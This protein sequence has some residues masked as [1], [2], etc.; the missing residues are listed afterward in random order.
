MKNKNM[1]SII[2]R[3][4]TFFLLG[5]LLAG[6]MASAQVVIEGNVYGGGNIGEVVKTADDGT[7]NTTVTVNGGTVGKK[8]GLEERKYDKDVQITRVDYGNVYGG[9][10]G[11]E[12]IGTNPNGSPIFNPNAGRVQGNT[13]VYV[14]GEAV[15]RRAVYGGGNIATVGIATIPQQTGIAA[16][17]SGGQATV[18]ITGN[19]LIGP[20]MED[21]TTATAEELA[22]SGIANQAD[23]ADSAFKYLGG[24]EGWVFGSS[25]GISG[26]ALRHLSFVDETFVNINGNAQVMNVFGSGENGH[27]QKGTNVIVGGN[28]IVGGVPLHGTSTPAVYTV[29][30]GAYNGATLHLKA[31]E[32]ELIEDE[33]GVGRE[34]TRGNVFGGGKGSDFISWF[35]NPKYCYT[36]GR[37]YGNT[38]VTIEENAKIYNRVFGGGLIAMVGTFV[39]ETSDDDDNHTIIGIASGGHTYVNIN[40]GTIG[41]FSATAGLTGLNNGD[42]YGGGRGLPGR[43]RKPGTG[44]H[45]LEPLAPLHQVVDEAYVGHTHVTVTDG[46]IYN[47]VYGGGANGHVQGNTYVTI[48]GGTIGHDLG[49][50][51]GNVFAGGGGTARYKEN[52]ALNLSITAGR[53]FGDTYLEITG[54]HVLHNVYGGGAIASVGTYNA[55]EL[56]NPTHPYLGFGHSNITITGGEIGTDGDNNGMV[57]GSG[58]GEIAEPGNFLDYVT[59]VAFSEVNIGTGTVNASTGEA[60]NL[61]GNAK[62]NGSVYGS[63]ENGHTYMEAVINVFGGTIGCTADEYAAMTAD[64]KEKKFPFRGN[65]YGAGCGTDR[66]ILNIVGT[67]TTWAYNPLAGVVQGNTKVNI[68]GGKISRSVYG[69]GAMASVGSFTIDEAHTNTN[70]SAALSWPYKLTYTTIT[71]ANNEPVTTG[72]TEVNIRGGHIGTLAAPVAES[73]NVFGSARGDVGPLGTMETM[74]IVRE[75]EVEVNFAPPT[76]NVTD[77]TPNVIIGSVYG[78]GENGT[79]YENTKVTMTNG[80]V[81]GSVFGGGDGT[82]TYMVALK[83]P[84]NPSSYLD[85]SPQRSITSGKVYGNTEVVINGGQVLHNVFGGGNLASVGKGNYMGYGELTNVSASPEPY[86]SS[87][88]CTVTVNGG[89][90][91]TTGYPG[92][93]YNNG[94]VFGSSKGTTFATVDNPEGTARY[95]YNRDFFLGYVNKTIVNI[96][97]TEG[98]GTG[99]QI[100]GAVFGGG[101]NGHVRWHTYV[102]VNKGEIGEE[103]DPT[104]GN[105]TDDKW[106][107][108]GNVYG[109]GLGTDMYDSDGDGDLDSYCPSAGSVTLNTNVT[110]NG[111][112]IHRN[113]YGGGSMATVG[114][115][116]TTDY[117]PGTSTCTVNINGGTIGQVV[118]PTSGAP[119][120]YGGNV[121]GAG[122]G[123]IDEHAPLTQYAAAVNTEVNVQIGNE[124]D[125]VIGNVYGGGSYG[126]VQEETNVNMK[127]GHVKG[128]VFGGGMGFETEVIAGLVKGNAT[129]DMTGGTIERSIYGGGQMGSVGTFTT[130][131]D[132][133]YNEGQANAFTSG[134]NVGLLGSLMP[135]EDHNPDDDDRGWIFCGGQGV[136]DSI[137]YPKAIALGVV[138]CTHLQISN[139]TSGENTIRPVVTASVYGG[140]ENGLVL[141]STFVEIAGGQIGT[142]HYKTGTTHHF[143]PI[144]EEDKWTT[145]ITA[146]NNGTIETALGTSGSL[147]DVFHECDAWEYSNNQLYDIFADETGYNS[148]GGALVGTNG[149]SFFGNVFG[150][151]SGYYPI[152]A[153]VWRRTA[154]QVNGNTRVEITGGHILTAVYGGNET[155][156][157]KGKSTV[158]MNG[159]TVGIPRTAVQIAAN[160]LSGNIYGAGMGDPRSMFNT[161]TNVKKT[162][163][164]LTGGTVFGNVYGGSR[165]G[166]VLDSTLVVIGQEQGKSTLIGTTGFSG[167]D[168]LVFGGGMGNVDYFDAEGRKFPVGR[169][170]GNTHVRM[171]DGKVL[172]SIYGGGLVALGG[173]NVEGWIDSHYDA[174]NHGRAKVEVSGGVIGNYAHDGLDLLL[175]DQHVGNVFGG[176][177]GSVEE[178]REDDLGRVGNAVVKISG[179][180]T[181]YGSVYGGGQMANVGFWDDYDQWYHEGTAF[182]K[183]SISGS[184][185]IGTQKE[186][187]PD[188]SSGTGTLTPKWTFYDVI[189]GVKMINHTLTGNVFGGGKGDVKLDEDGYV[190]GLEHGHCGSSE[191]SIS[192]TPTIRSSVFGGSERGAVW[193]DAKVNI[194]GGTIGTV[195]TGTDQQQSTYNFGSVF[196][197]SYGADA[198]QHFDM[199]P[200]NQTLEYL[201]KVDSVNLLAGRVYG[202]TSVDITG[203]VVRGNVFGGGDMASVGIWDKVLDGNDNLIDIVAKNDP[204]RPAFRGNATVNVG[205]E[206]VIGPLDNT[207]LNAYVFGGGKGFSY[208]P[209]EL[210]KA[211]SN[212]DSTFVTINGGKIWGSVYGG[213]SD[214]HVLGST[215]VIV[216]SGANIGDD[217]LS[218]WDGNIFGGGRNFFNSNHTNGRVAGNVTIDMDGGT[219]QGSV[220]GGGR[221]A[222]TGVN[223]LGNP[224][225]TEHAYDSAFNNKPIHGLATINVSGTATTANGVTTYSTNIGNPNGNELLNGSNESVG[226][227]YG[228]G[229]GDTKNYEDILAG[230]V[231]NTKVGISGSPRIYGSVFGGGEMAGVGYWYTEDGKAKFYDKSGTSEVTIGREGESD[232]PVIGTDYEFTQEYAATNPEWTIYDD[233]GT[234]IHTCTGNVFGGCQGDVD[235][236]APH[237]VSMG[238]SRN[239]K[240]VVNGGT[241]KSRVFGGAEQGSMAGNTSV[242]IN[243]G[244]IG[245]LV[246]MSTNGGGGNGDGRD[247]ETQYYM[248]G[249]Y[250]GG[251]GSHNSAYNVPHNNDSTNI[252]SDLL[253]G[254]VYG[255]ARVDVLGGTV[256]GSVFGGAS[257]AYLGG[258]GTNP[259]GNAKVYIGS[260]SQMGIPDVGTTIL[261]GVYGAN[262]YNGTPYGDVEVHVYHTAHTGQPTTAGGNA[263]PTVPASGATP[264]WLAT[265]PNGTD[266]FALYQVFGGGNRANYTPKLAANKATV[267]VYG[268]EENTIYELYGGGNAAE[269]G[270][271]TA[272][273][274]TDANVIIEGGRIHSVFG[275][276]NG[277]PDPANIYGIA[278]TSVEGGLIDELFGGSNGYGNV[279]EINLVVAE[280]SDCELAIVNGYGGGN[281]SPEI[282]EIIATLECCSNPTPYNNF[283]GGAHSAVIYGN[284]TLNVYGGKVTNLFGG[285]EGSQGI[286]ADIKKYPTDWQTG[287]Y[288]DE[289]K[290][291]MQSHPDLAGTG[292][293]VTVNLYGGTHTNVFGGCDVNG[294]IEGVVTVN[295]LDV[296]D[297]CPLKIANIYGASNETPYTPD[298]IIVENVPQKPVSP[299]INVVHIKDTDGISQNVFGAGK[300]NTATVTS[301]PMVNIGYNHA[302]M[303]QYIPLDANGDSI[304]HVQGRTPRAYVKGSVYGGGEYG[305]VIGNPS[306]NINRSNTVVDNFVYG[307]GCG[308]DTDIDCAKVTGGTTVR[309]IDGLIKRSV[310]GGGEMA[311]VT[312]DTKVEMSGGTVGSWET[313]GD[314]QYLHGSI[315]GGGQGSPNP[316]NEQ[317]MDAADYGR[318]D[319]NT[320]IDI[321]GN[322]HILK[323]VY[324]GGQMGSVGNGNLSDNTTG[325]A[326][327]T[328]SGGQIGPFVADKKNANVYG[329]GQGEVD[330][331]YISHYTTHAN[332]DS[333]SVIVCDS[334]LI[335]GSVFG[336]SANGHVLAGTRVLVEKGTNTKDKKP[337]IGT[338]GMHG[339]DGHVYGGGQGNTS[340]FSAGRVGGNTKVVMT[341]GTVMGCIYGGGNVAL[342]GVDVDGTFA[343]FID[344]DQKYDSI[345]HGM[346]EVVVSGGIIGNPANDGLDLLR[347]NQK[348]G[349]IY[350]GGRGDPNEYLEDDFGRAANA[351]VSISGSPTIYGSVFGGGQMA[352]VGHWNNYSDW[353]TTQ[354]GTTRVTINGAPQIGTAL[355]FDHDN[356]AIAEPLPIKTLYDTINDVRMISHTSTGNVFGGGQGDMIIDEEGDAE[357]FEQG[358][359]CTTIVNINMNDG[360]HIMSSVF[361][362]SEQGAVWGDTKVKIERGVI[363]TSGIEADSLDVDLDEW[364][365]ASNLYRFGSVFGGSYGVDSYKHL[366]S[367]DAA[368]ADTANSYAGRVYGNTYVNITGGSICGNVFGGGNMASVGYWNKVLDDNDNLIDFVPAPYPNTIGI[369][370][371]AKVN[372]S[373]AAIIGPLDPNGLNASVYGGGKGIGDD[374]DDLR[375]KYGNV[376]STE[377]TINLGETGHVY[378]S[379]FGGGADG[380]VLRDAVVNITGGTIGTTGLHDDGLVFGGGQGTSGSFSAGRVGGN[381]KVEMTDGTVLGNI[382]GGG[383][384]ALTGVDVNGSFESYESLVDGVHVYDSIRHGLARVEVSGGTIGNHNHSGLDLLLNDLRVGNIYGGGRGDLNEFREDDFGRSANAMVHIYNSPTIYGSVYGGGQMANVGRWNDYD[385][386]Y[387]QKTGATKVTIDGTPTI[388]TEKEF[389]YAYSTGTGASAPKWTLYEVIN[390]MRMITYTRTGNVYGS[391]Q[392]NIKLDNDGYVVG[393]E[394]GHCRT[395]EVN[396]S[397]TPTI[398]SSVYGGAEQ[399]AVWGDT[400]VNITGG[401]IGTENIVAGNSDYYSYGSVYGGSYG[402]DAYTHL[403][404]TNPSQQVL[405]SV[406]DLAGHVYGNTFV[407]ITGGAVRC[408]VFGGGDMASVGEWDDD[409]VPVSNTGNATV[410]VS[411]S[412]IVGPMDGTGLNAYVFG[413]GKGIG[414][415]P[416]N[417]RKEYCNINSTNVTVELNE[418]GDNVGRVYGSLY[419]GGSDCHVLGDTYV[420]LNSGVIGTYDAEHSTISSW[421]GNIFGGGRNFLKTNYAAGR[422]AG[423]THVEMKGGT[424]YGAIFGGG[425]HA[426]TG[427]GLDGMTMLDGENH[428]NTN[429]EV[430]GGIVGC[431]DIVTSFIDRPIGEVYGGGKGSMVGITLPGH[432]S[433][434]ALFIS[435]VKNTNVEISQANPAVPTRILNTV[436][437]GG[438]TANVGHYTWTTD[439]NG[440]EIS[441]IA[442]KPGTGKTNVTIKG[443]I[444]GVDRSVMSYTLVPGTYTLASNPVGNV[445]GGGKGL[446][447][448][449]ANYA[450]GISTVYGHKN[451]VDIMGTVGSTTVTVEN[452]SETIRPW[453]KGSVFGGSASGHV[454]RDTEVTIAGGQ[455]GAGDSG[456]ADV[457]YT[458]GEDNNQFFNPIEYF[459][460]EHTDLDDVASE[461]ALYEC[462]HWPYNEP[463]RP[464]DILEIAAGNTP[465]DGKT[466]FGNVYGGGSGFLPYIT[467]NYN[468]TADTA[469]W[470]RESGKVYGNTK[471]TITGGHILTNVYGGCETADVGL[472]DDNL[473]NISGGNDTIIMTGGT[474]GV[475]RTLAQIAAHPLTCYLFGA[476]KGDPRTQFD[477]WTNVDS[478]YVEVSG[479]IIYGS[480]FG[481]GEEGHVMNDVEVVIKDEAIIGTTGTSYVDGNIFG[482]GRGFSGEALTAGTVGGNVKVDIQD[483]ITLGSVY[484]GGRL[485]SVGTH[486]TAPEDDNYGQFQE[487]TEDK[488]H[489]Y[490]TIDISGGRIGNTHEYIYS[491][492]PEHPEKKLEATYGGNVFAGAMGRLTKLDGTTINPLWPSLG[493]VKQTEVTVSGNAEIW[494]SVYGGGQF[495]TVRDNATVNI[496]GGT[497]GTDVK[498]PDYNGTSNN[499]HYHFGSVYGGGLGSKDMRYDGTYANDSTESNLYK[500]PVEIAGRVYGNTFVNISG[501]QV[502]ENVFGGGEVAS[503]GMVKDGNFVKGVATV[504]VNGGEV[505]PM[506]M[507]GLNAHVYG[508]SKGV[509]KDED[510][511]YKAYCNV[512]ET[513]VTVEKHI[514]EGG[515]VVSSPQVWGSV[516]GGGSDGHVLGDAA[517]NFN[518]GTLGSTG[519][520]T[521]DGN[522]FGGGRNFSASNLTAGR[523]GGNATV[524]VTEGHILG[525]IFGGGRL[526]SVGIDEDGNMQEGNNHGFTLVNV[527]GDIQTGEIKIGHG[528]ANDH[529]QVGGNVYGSGKGIAGPSTSIYPK[530]AQVKQTVVNIKEREG[531]ET[532]IEGSV[533]G[534]GEDG[535]VLKDTYVNIFGGQIGGHDYGDLTPCADPYHGNV[536]GAGRGIDTYT[537]GGTQYYSATAGIVRGNTN[538]NMYG[539]H[540]VRNVYGGGNL[541]SVG[542]ANETPDANGNYHTGL[543]SVTIVGGTV[544]TIN[545]NENFGNVFGSGHGGSGGEYVHLAY[546]KNTHVTIGQTARIYGS[547]FGGGED[548]HV[549]MNAIVDIEGGIIGDEDDVANQPLDGNVYGG[550]RGLLLNGES[551][552]AG[553]VY[554]YTTVNIKNSTYNE[555]NYSPIIWNNVYG[556]GSQ[557]VVQQ[558]KV[559][560]MSGGLVHGNMF[561]GS[562]QVPTGRPNKAPRWVNMWGGTVEGNVY[563]CSYYGV[564][565][566]PSTEPY[567]P[568]GCASFVNISGGTIGT[569]ANGNLKGGNVYGAGYGGKVK[570]S[571]AVLIGKNAIVETSKEGGEFEH[572]NIHRQ[573]NPVISNLDI[574]GSVF[575][576]SFGTGGS[577][578]WDHSFNVTGY[579]KVY[580][581]GTAYNTTNSSPAGINNYMNIG[582]GLYGCGT[583][584]ESGDEG[585]HILVRNYGTRNPEGDPEAELT[586]ASRTLTTI[587]R[588]DTVMLENTNIKLSGALDISQSDSDRAFAVLQIDSGLYV[589][590]ASG[591]VLGAVGAPAY[592]DSIHEVRSLHLIN[593][594]SSYGHMDFSDDNYWEWI[595]VNPLVEEGITQENT[596]ENAR[597]YYMQTAPS[598]PLDYNQENVIIFNDDS[599]L[600]V[601]YLDKSGGNKKRMYGQLQ[602]FFRMRGDFFRPI[603]TESFAYARPKVTPKNNPIRVTGYDIPGDIVNGSDGGFLSYNT[604]HNFFTVNGQKVLYYEY[605]TEGDDGGINFTKTKQY[606][607]FNI[608]EYVQNRESGEMDLEEFREWVLPRL[609]GKIWYVDGRGIGNGGWGKDASH[610]AGWGHF[611][612]M[613]KLT[614]SGEKTIGEG[615]GATTELGICKDLTVDTY[616]PFNFE[617]DIIYVV[618][619]VEAIKEDVNGLLNQNTEYSLKLYRYPGGHKMRNGQIDGTD[620]EH[621]VE[622][623]T[624][625]P[626]QPY[627]GLPT[628]ETAGPGAN[629]GMMIHANKSNFVMENVLVDGLFGAS[630][631]DITTHNIPTSFTST[632]MYNVNKPMVVVDTVGNPSK[633][634]SLTLKGFRTTTNVSGE[635][636]VVTNGTI[637]QQGY[638]GIDA[639]TTWYYDADYDCYTESTSGDQQVITVTPQGGGLFVDKDASSTV[640]VEG[641]VTIQG[642]K[643]RH[644]NNTVDCNVYLPTFSKYLNITNTLRPATKIGITSPMC[645]ADPTYKTNTLSPVAVGVR[646]GTTPVQVGGETIQVSNA[647]LDADSSWRKCNF[648]DD[649]GWFFVNKH[650]IGD[651]ER[652][653]YY[654]S[655]EGEVVHSNNAVYFGWTWANIVRQKPDGYRVSNDSIYISSPQGLAWLISKSAGKNEQ[656]AIDFTI[657]ETS[658]IYKIVQTK[659]TIDLI[660]YVWVPVG[661]NNQGETF[662]GIFDGQG[663]LIKNLSIE[664]IGKGDRCYERTNYGLFG[665]AQNGTVNRTFVVSGTINPANTAS[666]NLS[667]L[668]GYLDNTTV[669]NSEAAV[670]IFCPNESESQNVVAGGLVGQMANGSKIHSS[671]AMPDMD[672]NYTSKGLAGGLVGSANAGT[673]Y[674]SFANAKFKV[675][676]LTIANPENPNSTPTILI[677]NDVKIGGLVGDNTGAVMMNCYMALQS[678]YENLT[679]SNFGS[680]AA[681]NSSNTNI[682]R[683]Y[684]MSKLV[685][686]G[687]EPLF[688]YVID[689]NGSCHTSCK[690]YTPVNSADLLGYMYADNKVVGITSDTDTTLFQVLNYWVDSIN[691]KQNGH[692]YARWAR[693]GLPEINGDLP[694]LMLEDM[695]G[696]KAHQGDFRTVATYEGGPVLQYGGP[697]RDTVGNEPYYTS[698]QLDGTLARA[699]AGNSLFIYGDVTVASTKPVAA[700]KV[701]IYEHA[702]IKQVGSLAG[703]SENPYPNT[704]VG[705]TFDNSCGEATSTPS[706][707]TGLN[708]LGMGGFPLP[709]DWHMLSTPLS[710]APLGFNY[711][712][713]GTNTN[714]S[715]YHGENHSDEYY[716]NNPWMDDENDIEFSWLQNG[717]DNVRY[718]MKG[719]TNSQSQKPVEEGQEQETLNLETW[720]DGYFPSQTTEFGTGLISGNG[721]DEYS[722]SGEPRYPYGMD[723]YTWTEP[724][725]HWINFKRN[726][727][728]HWHSDFTVNNYH[729][730][731]DY[732]PYGDENVVNQ[733]E[734]DLI[735]GRGYMMAIATETFMQSHGTLNSG[736]KGIQ[737][738]KTA[739]SRL[740]GWNL[741]GNPYHGYIDF[742]KVGLPFYVVYNA[743]E[744][745]NTGGGEGGAKEDKA[746]TAFRY[747]PKGGSIKGDY[748]NQFI[749]PHQGFFVL[750]QNAGPDPLPLVFNESMIVPRSEVTNGGDF[751]DWQP[752]YPLVNLYLSSDH[753]CADVT[754]IEFERPEWGGAHKLKEL[755]VGNGLFYGHHEDENYAAL[756]V[757]EGTKRVPVRFE[758]KEDDIFTLKWNTANGDF[759]SMYLIDNITG[760]QY[761][762]LRN[763]TYAFE[764]HKSDYKSRFLIVFEVTDVEEN[765]EGFH[766][767]VFFDGSQWIA[768]G[769]GNL[770]FI[771]QLGHVL[772]SERLTGGQTRISLPEV[773]KSLYMFRLTNSKET[774]VQ[775]VLVK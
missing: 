580:I 231:A 19:A 72:K 321:S 408:N 567:D 232:N 680:I 525:S 599:R 443:G 541:A 142:G 336:G 577:T 341:D 724:D 696:N 635:I 768:T 688:D 770:E 536:Y 47:S 179:S 46:T 392:G 661:D 454:L 6:G 301:N 463:Y 442:M 190:V 382:Y 524:T 417:L 262:N 293:N 233:D 730:H 534:S 475:P 266:N 355:E 184:P 314:E 497:I 373:G 675:G 430:K 249:V 596:E 143:D 195:V 627:N 310:F 315:Y 682:K 527:G 611:P 141:D 48:N 718:W 488:T 542:N 91:G 553:E 571:V 30:G 583:N 772:W 678:G 216:H 261:G 554:G 99:P 222:L 172:G 693:P 74:A 107:Y 557:S 754:V 543:A 227:I 621:P 460:T 734:D 385:T 458:D 607:Y 747:Y 628:G 323:D 498:H 79:V 564:D 735:V 103:Y 582:G 515:D 483:G 278:T 255:N 291:F 444:I 733:N 769:E 375:K 736:N 109:A 666:T 253:A 15:V 365:T 157:V 128:S 668:V 134:G 559:V 386:W 711:E 83:D 652:T 710:N 643:Q 26:G 662:N 331:D 267:H 117:D 152:K 356:Y 240:V 601:R 345:Q 532:W 707:N 368:V 600:Y 614:I 572:S 71:D 155:T 124:T 276:G 398:M 433:A 224:Y 307:A 53:V 387:T 209:D 538:V 449:P 765:L 90:I 647:V 394:H 34:I 98:E 744:Y 332:V 160:P 159:G 630:G 351:D 308:N 739:N 178:Y 561:G 593:A 158:K 254:R 384:V 546:V 451:L 686:Q 511:A 305:K 350:G 1:L 605:T 241:I 551:Q 697:V 204:D 161:M 115:L 376:N 687:Y 45:G 326:H 84:N 569:D 633:Q 379:V 473:D 574:K 167:F 319:G 729:W 691:K 294:N 726:G 459:E 656:A 309:I 279:N 105:I 162:Q 573:E 263:Y 535:H 154:G 112:T 8:L 357:G 110:V 64:E 258:Y 340:N 166:H 210:R 174:V 242:V 684:V 97:S 225:V 62:I 61:S 181:V 347:S 138:N 126:Q 271:A 285:S 282:G 182:T 773:A 49:G 568:K 81:R 406:N 50:W 547:V 303:A 550:G 145:A 352:N 395:T 320:Y 247:G 435:L 302:T 252:S 170:G 771:D 489:G 722:A 201:Q 713:N 753:G 312:G 77:A 728:N 31:T 68:Y 20:K 330:E 54:G 421:G 496:M 63:G 650:N 237:W 346:A 512:N 689:N 510:N 723:F 41:S 169:V 427:V 631:G 197:G 4:R 213:G 381:T 764:G 669:K 189:N 275:G 229:K 632:Q 243:G 396:I 322:A 732:K 363:G 654:D 102:N 717:S 690:P 667:G 304:Y 509:D 87:G 658:S 763:D 121:Y 437:G 727:P 21:L 522:I 248:G 528:A 405:D 674:N 519:E 602:G 719:W 27:V 434:S 94:F 329:G 114:P 615:Q 259:H 208:D 646:E 516:F 235:I 743:D 245:T 140:A 485:A 617:E 746:G 526:G 342:T 361:G 634:S 101:D 676:S 639:A 612:D 59:Y 616:E 150:G 506:D 55:S 175:S 318:V 481:G 177:R 659:D 411:G 403:N 100:K 563:G 149:H 300:G 51:H 372:V 420:T 327:V 760:I 657:P 472:Y 39:E 168:G 324:G 492:D 640:N 173:V 364:V 424:I 377:V 290:A 700:D 644:K 230:R 738:T 549:R 36:S 147:H 29:V 313:I 439:P 272:G 467:R 410:N 461:D 620:A 749:H 471:V 588:A 440:Y 469:V 595:G 280:D 671:M 153:G 378:G 552:T 694:V 359:C 93:G 537:Q 486:F 540:I 725:Y 194:T 523:V 286:P 24:N 187:D 703:T 555:I 423:N 264:E 579:S 370:G 393:T 353:Y 130:Y 521:L 604:D 206:A 774:K 606:P 609:T 401:T 133:I 69:A 456:T 655:N 533:F 137:T 441:N 397:G 648:L 613:P 73:G 57:F 218:T 501:G 705:V 431:E 446:S 132:V 289:V 699:T 507:N 203:G 756:F 701:S 445:F 476:G 212:V 129:V 362:G 495:G 268:C 388:G 455:I 556:G 205:G 484:G 92:D 500:R 653:T 339:G 758:A 587:Q 645:N 306:V 296:E 761:D 692:E 416:Y 380:H 217:G 591:I 623:P 238:R 742:D 480:V 491:P 429:V 198:Y 111:G 344:D 415:D 517:V 665:Y 584:C 75:T 273:Y 482:G 413:G 371:H 402:M 325:V 360:G 40:G 419:G 67:D 383:S 714:T 624:E 641:L 514:G 565:D 250:G 374:P 2:F 38:H 493:K 82:D 200:S 745:G 570:G 164:Y 86:Q 80:L 156:D 775:K 123:I 622:A 589:T 505:G 171:T 518:G 191:V 215:S 211:Y 116:P 741:V 334:A 610:Q 274:T 626:E 122:R 257:F 759:H 529:D 113:V 508:G 44:P 338:D 679:A 199:N 464:F 465:C 299:V 367:N 592:M 618:G 660:Q 581:D 504:I 578:E 25:R 28:A 125:K 422:V 594:T 438:E 503:V 603:G 702:S 223:M 283:Y 748:A 244:T 43:P 144:Y 108:R 295:V 349:N 494:S 226:D 651:G 139:T 118:T 499:K 468:N 590:N 520:T 663:H 207:G 712:V 180:P 740:P 292:G 636:E 414:N 490:V 148:Q 277:N 32:G 450:Q 202:N 78:S 165:E 457:W 752:A 762:M 236:T 281:I 530:L 670:K 767:F 685:G 176:G 22:A 52:N 135:W 5:M 151:G 389:D 136:A 513:H 95:D 545:E 14:G 35:A 269:I 104:D 131:N 548:G 428:G 58:R 539:G 391:G 7:G 106:A 10:N 228:S 716:Y 66:Y 750:A 477:T 358:H 333:T 766:N 425:R 436:Y 186:F 399:G 348:L 453:V 452:T 185:T 256:Q 23:Y 560:N 42:V 681:Q 474:I 37:V 18:T 76:G 566:N 562:R 16:Y 70:T 585:R 576:G 597:L 221:M 708:G 409:F 265:I 737:L 328:I 619:P 246:T 598:N 720:V 214:S 317:Y 298:D 366:H 721:S 239:A 89:T 146:I 407:N 683:S 188:Y 715:G 85:P 119:F 12:I 56:I 731:L 478:V 219:I 755:C 575:G 629:L 677:N 673:I 487:D 369:K 335:Y 120:N 13:T 17:E 337:I 390:G 462:Y 288:S 757:K 751:R 88:I 193:G 664:C 479:G 447:D 183:V 196:G 672:V 432:P 400:K 284:V 502:L 426:V 448:N 637:L 412:A 709:R 127:A 297:N 404:L 260:E 316:V 649:Q 704:Y 544:G 695:N 531:F 311:I 33:Y 220:F 3:R 192:G 466:W 698:P 9:G 234:I 251:Y 642:N 11:Y 706:I 638:N 354:T 418:A 163:V 586:Q 625:T 287:D 343:S 270:S 558:Y 470:N 96:G 60:S 608:G 65:V